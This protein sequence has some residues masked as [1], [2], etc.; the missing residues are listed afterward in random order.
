[1]FALAAPLST[2]FVK[3]YISLRHIFL[4]YDMVFYGGSGKRIPKTLRGLK[5]E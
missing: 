2:F 1:M 5:K 4:F 3:C